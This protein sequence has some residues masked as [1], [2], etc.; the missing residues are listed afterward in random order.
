VLFTILIGGSL[1]VMSLVEVLRAP[2]S[3]VWLALLALT[4]CAGWATLRVPSMPISFSISETFSVIAALIGPAAGAI[5]AALDGLVLSFRMARTPRALHRV[6][7]NIA[8]PVISTWTAAQLFFRLADA[9][10]AAAGAAGALRLLPAEHRHR[11]AGGR[12]RT[13]SPSG[14]HLA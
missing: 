10:P 5:T 1:A 6:L 9:V 14:D 11:G 7:F 4:A 13:T 12:L 3:P 2:F 8:A